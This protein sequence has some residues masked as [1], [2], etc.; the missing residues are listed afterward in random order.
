MKKKRLACS[1]LL[2]LLAGSLGS[3]SVQAA[4][5]TVTPTLIN[6]SYTSS[7]AQRGD[8][9]SSVAVSQRTASDS[10]FWAYYQ[11]GHSYSKAQAMGIITGYDSTRM[12]LS[13]F[14]GNLDTKIETDPVY[15]GMR[16]IFAQGNISSSSTVGFQY[17]LNTSSLP[18]NFTYYG[19]GK[20]NHSIAGYMVDYTMNWLGDYTV[21]KGSSMIISKSSAKSSVQDSFP[22]GLN[23]NSEEIVDKD[24]PKAKNEFVK[25][26]NGVDKTVIFEV[27]WND[28]FNNPSYYENLANEKTLKAKDALI[29]S[30]KWEQFKQEYENSKVRSLLE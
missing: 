22:E 6:G 27:S 2:L 23:I 19:P 10:K 5:Y 12:V 16:T 13:S 25:F 17:T 15:S 1:A 4:S 21:Y 14:Y 28:Y 9:A 29:K 7:Y 3:G 24:S 30:G 18:F 8:V 20:P 26:V 11:V